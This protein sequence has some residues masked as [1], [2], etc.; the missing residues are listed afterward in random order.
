[1]A[2]VEQPAMVALA[3][4]I[5]GGSD[6]VIDKCNVQDSFSPSGDGSLGGYFAR[7]HPQTGRDGNQVQ[8]HTDRGKRMQDAW[9]RAYFRT[10]I[11]EQ[12]S[13]PPLGNARLRVVPG[14]QNTEISE[15]MMNGPSTYAPGELRGQLMP[16]GEIVEPGHPDGSPN[17]GRLDNE[18]AMPLDRS[19]T[20]VWTTTALHSTE[21]QLGP[22]PR[23]VIEWRCIR[24]S[25]RNRLLLKKADDQ[26]DPSR[27]IPLVFPGW[28]R[29][30]TE[31]KRLWGVESYDNIESLRAKL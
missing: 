20:L 18:V 28:Q 23:R 7:T 11:D 29:W 26:R 22:G 13:A 12:N 9:P 17:F 1:M 3:R 14:T 27:A 19:K 4:K 21:V 2:T 25:D 24:E 10:A 16:S 6:V 15:G 31:R 8:W 5:L 30:S